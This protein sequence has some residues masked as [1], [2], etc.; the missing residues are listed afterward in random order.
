MIILTEISLN[1]F[2][3]LSNCQTTYNLVKEVS[4]MKWHAFICRSS[5]MKAALLLVSCLVIV[6]MADAAINWQPGN[7]ALNCHFHGGDFL[8]QSTSGPECG[9][10]CAQTAGNWPLIFNA[11]LLIPFRNVVNACN[12]WRQSLN[13]ARVL[14]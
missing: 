14:N 13:D 8:R 2:T 3:L 1:K 7:W 4:L 6:S 12:K 9:G 10:R 11:R 5:K